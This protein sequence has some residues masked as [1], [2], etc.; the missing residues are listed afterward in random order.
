MGLKIEQSFIREWSFSSEPRLRVFFLSFFDMKTKQTVT[1]TLRT[2]KPVGSRA[3]IK[4]LVNATMGACNSR[5]PT[6]Q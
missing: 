5:I 3:N 2:S 1:V 6:L 4:Y